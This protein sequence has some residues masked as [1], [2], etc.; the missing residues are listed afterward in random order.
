MS[1][2]PEDDHNTKDRR[3]PIEI[4]LFDKFI[5]K[6]L[7]LNGPSII[8]LVTIITI[9]ILPSDVA[10]Y[11]GQNLAL[12]SVFLF[13]GLQQL[14]S[15]SNLP[16]DDA[17]ADDVFDFNTYFVATWCLGVV[18][19]TYLVGPYD[20]GTEDAIKANG[21]FFLSKAAFVTLMSVGLL[22]T[23]GVMALPFGKEEERGI[24]EKAEEDTLS[25]SA[26]KELMDLWDEE[27][28]SSSQWNDR[29]D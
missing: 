16:S 26:E 9:L 11:S 10:F 4:S 24:D 5:D 19:V 21:T 25:T 17:D 12:S 1:N 7:T 3:Q 27:L 6:A 18:F 29:D 8:V 2:L 13:L 14:N 20:F 15:T 23:S 28:K 22:S